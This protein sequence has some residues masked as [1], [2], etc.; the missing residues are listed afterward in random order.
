MREI[1]KHED[2]LYTELEWL[3]SNIDYVVFTEN[4]STIP[5]TTKQFRKLCIKKS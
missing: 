1:K 2:G 3:A 5:F 4:V